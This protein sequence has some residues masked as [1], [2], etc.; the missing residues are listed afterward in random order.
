M[1]GFF[2]AL[3][4]GSPGCLCSDA[5]AFAPQQLPVLKFALGF[6]RRYAIKKKDELERVAKANR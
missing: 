4:A 3:P 5:A 6:Q 1:S 2:Q